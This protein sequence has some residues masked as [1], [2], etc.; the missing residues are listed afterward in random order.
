MNDSAQPSGGAPG[1]SDYRCDRPQARAGTGN[2]T[3]A[4][5]P[6]RGGASAPKSHPTA[7]HGTGGARGRCLRA[8]GA[9]QPARRPGTGRELRRFARGDAYDEQPMPELDSEAIDLRRNRVAGRVFHRLGLIEQWGSGIQ[10]MTA[11]SRDAGLPPPGLDE[12]GTRFRVTLSTRR[13][14]APVLDRIDAAILDCLHGDGGRPTS[15]I[16][17]VIHLTSRSTRPGLAR[18]VER[19]FVREVGTSP[20]DH[21]SVQPSGTTVQN[22]MPSGCQAACG[23]QPRL[24]GRAVVG[25]DSPDE[26]SSSGVRLCPRCPCSAHSPASSTVRLVATTVTWRLEARTAPSSTSPGLSRTRPSSHSGQRRQF[27]R[28]AATGSLGP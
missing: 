3:V 11:A 1:Q 27:A 21:V 7:L 28:R 14:G 17:N 10:P 23:F 13:V 12:I 22:S 20:Q 9:H 26:P 24:N 18:P 2:P 8:G 16:A 4:P 19:G 15:E 25:S 5:H 6:R